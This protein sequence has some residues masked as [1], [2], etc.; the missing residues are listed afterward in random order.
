MFK[1][2]NNFVLRV[3]NLK[4]IL[5]F[6]VLFAIA[7]LLVNFTLSTGVKNLTQTFNYSP[8]KAYQM[9]NDYGEI[10]RQNHLRILSADIILVILY[11]ILF[12]ASI[13]YTITRLFPSCFSLH[14]ISLL[15]FM[16]AFMQLLE[17]AGVFIL[18][19]NFPKELFIVAKITNIITVTK[20]ILTYIC[21]LIPVTGFIILLL[22]NIIAFAKR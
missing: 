4:I 21:I 16:L 6:L 12:S 14:K 10:G 17:I 3:A 22:R 13:M 11:T 15:P 7:M 1:Y 8:S 19:K 9:I 2:L 5:L 18:L 20:Y